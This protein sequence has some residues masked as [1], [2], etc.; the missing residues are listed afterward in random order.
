[1]EKKS[2][3]VSKT[4]IVNVLMIVG[5]VAAMAGEELGKGTGISVIMINAVNIVLRFF[6]TKP[7]K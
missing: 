6:T 2:P 5:T 7:V 4:I 3:F 1:M